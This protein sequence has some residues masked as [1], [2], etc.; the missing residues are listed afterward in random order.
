MA[1]ELHPAVDA[2]LRLTSLTF[3]DAS[4]HDSQHMS[5]LVCHETEVLVGD[6]HYGVSHWRQKL[7]R[8][9]GVRV[10]APPHYK[11]KRGLMT[12][13][14]NRLLRA[15][16]KIEAVFGLLKGKHSLVTSYPRSV[17]GYLVHCLRSLLGYQLRRL[18]PA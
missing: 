1:P 13:E 18:W 10:V 11:Q 9:Y 5:K 8:K 15:R 6:S 16:S 7:R 17:R 2:R 14:D 4:A 3:S 12:I